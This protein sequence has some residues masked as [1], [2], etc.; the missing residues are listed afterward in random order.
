MDPRRKIGVLCLLA[1]LCRLTAAAELSNERLAVSLDPRDGYAVTQIGNRA[2]GVNFIA[3]RPDGTEEDR[4]LWLLHVRDAKG[5]VHRVGPANAR[6]VAEQ[7]E[8]D[9]VAITWK[10]VAGAEAKTDLA[11]IVRVSLPPDSIKS[12][13]TIEVAGTATGALWQVDFPRIHG[14]RSIGDDEMSLPQF[15]GRLVRDPTNH[16]RNLA[17]NY[18]QP[19]SMQFLSYWGTPDMRSPSLET[20][21]DHTNETGWA[22]DRSDAAGLYLAAEDGKIYFKRFGVGRQNIPGQMSWRIENLPPIEGWPIQPGQQRTIAYKTPYPIAV[23]VFRGDYHEAAAIYLEW[24]KGQVWCRRGTADAWPTDL[25]A[26]DSDELMMWTPPWFREIGFWAKYYH[27][28]AKIVPE[29][30]AYRKWLRVPMA[31]HYYRYHITAFNDND[32]EHLPPDPY[33][34]DGVRDAQDLGVRPMPYVLSTIWDTDTQSW[35]RE[36]GLPSSMKNDAGEIYPW[37]IGQ[38]IF[39]WMCPATEQWRAKM[40]ETC[41]KLIWEH[42][43]NGVYLDV[44]AAGGAMGC[45]DP[46]HGHPVHGG[47]YQGQGNRKLMIDLRRDIR[48]LDPRAAFFTEEID[49]IFLDCMDGFLTLDISRS[50][51]PD[52]EQVWPILTAVYHPYTIN[53]GSDANLALDPDFFA[54]VYGE[55]FIWGSQPLNS[56]MEPPVPRDGDPASEILREATRAYYVAG[57]RFLMGGKWL[58]IAVRPKDAR[59]GACGL[60][61][62]ADRHVVRYTHRKGHRRI[63]TGPAVMASAWERGGDVGVVMLNISDK[64][65]TAEL[66][67]RGQKLGVADGARLVRT[68][69]LEPEDAG[70]ADGAHTIRLAPRQAAVYVVTADVKRAMQVRRLDDTPWELLVVEKGP[71]PEVAGEA[72]TLW[73]CSDGP[74]RNVLTADGTKATACTW[75]PTG[76]LKPREG[77][78]A[79]VRGA[80]AEGQGLP[81]DLDKKPFLLMRKLPHTV[82]AAGKSE[83]LVLSGDAGHLLC[84]APGR[85][86]FQFA[87]PGV[88]VVSMVDSAKVVR[89]IAE[90]PTD[91]VRLPDGGACYVGYARFDAEDVNRLVATGDKEIARRIEPFASR[92]IGLASVPAERRAAELAAL[93]REFIE[94][95]RRFNDLPGALS[96]VIGLAALHKRVHALASAHV[97]GDV[98][99]QAKHRWLAPGIPKDLTLLAVGN[100]SRSLDSIELFAIGDWREG[101]MEIAPFRAD[102]TQAAGARV[103][104]TTLTLKDGLYVERMVPMIGSVKA[105]KDGVDFHLT[106]ILHLEANRPYE[107]TAKGAPAAVIAGRTGTADLRIRNWSPDPVGVRLSVDSPEGWRAAPDKA[108]LTAPALENTKVQVSFTPPAGIKSGEYIFRCTGNHADIADA[109]VFA[110]VHVAVLDALEPLSAQAGAWEAPPKESRACIR[111]RGT[112]AFHA[113]AGRPLQIT[114]ENIRVT[115]YTDKLGYRLLDPDLKVVEEGKVAVDKSKVIKRDAPATGVYRIEVAPERGSCEISV[116]HRGC[117]EAATRQTPLSLFVKPI[118]RSFYVSKGAKRIL[119]GAQD[120]G[121]TE[122]ARFVVTSP[123][124]RVAYDVKANY[125]GGETEIEVR[126]GEAGGIWTLRVEPAQDVTFWLGG[127]AC[128]YLATS[129]ERLLVP[130]SAR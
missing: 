100:A 116:G 7:R 25:P 17:L 58:R 62:A 86:E 50:Y 124:G 13:W 91:R 74:V 77:F 14:I 75:D 64:E 51:L 30:A 15:W 26:P 24:A 120:G 43:M 115:K 37:S 57:Q 93:T 109:A 113:D 99:L 125:Q 90:P 104:H 65:Q 29:W 45:Y 126:P 80:K 32:P 6:E 47:N 70:Q 42:G 79:E 23:G 9:G 38:E 19:A 54:L 110:D 18:P 127:D 106:D 118:T 66:T 3:P 98:V 4:S 117:V 39:A 103:S 129:P 112:L 101:Q 41:R 71:F 81:R 35:I 85:A 119:L 1:C 31:S 83:V 46:N 2:C 5:V 12:Y 20:D 122:P 68:W 21:A 88:V 55:Q 121:P 114:L 69:P 94:T 59:P 67:V 49:E 87:K 48:R 84:I 130:A 56:T 8:R 73:A 108:S 72:G 107:L 105:S 111:Q 10:G 27:E 33:L 61:L 63:W 40:R 123:T 96:P 52:T 97:A 36:N 16:C 89:S 92:L 76:E 53:F 34:L 44:L 11:V 82:R 28:P 95:A 102:E 22:P 128:P 78:Q 60:E